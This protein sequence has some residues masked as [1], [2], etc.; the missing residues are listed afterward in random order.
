MPIDIKKK[1]IKKAID[2]SAGII[3]NIAKKL[4][5]AWN[6]ARKYI[7]ADPE[8]KQLLADE[9]EKNIDK[10]ENVILNA[11]NEGD[12]QTAKW[13]LGTIG[14]QRGYTEKQ[15]IDLSSHYSD[16]TIEVIKSILD[17]K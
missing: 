2:G 12:I 6:S 10:A 9:I 1:D 15:E 17:K 4:N 13:Y 14:K 8:L 7:E 16:K 5:I 3:N 11:L